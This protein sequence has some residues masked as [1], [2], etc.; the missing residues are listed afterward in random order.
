MD[1][2][3]QI[4]VVDDDAIDRMAIHRSLQRSPLIVAT[5][6][7]ASTGG[8]AMEQLRSRPFHCAFLDYRLPDMDGLALIN[9]IRQ[10]DL[11]TPLIVLTGQGDEET[12]VEL[13][14]AGASDYLVKSRIQPDL[15]A[16]CV[17]SALRVYQAEQAV[18]AAQ[19]E[20]E[21]TNRLLR[22]Q[23]QALEANRR[24]IQRQNLELIRASQLKSDFLATLSH[25]LRTP[26]NAIIGFSQLLMRRRQTEWTDKQREMVGRIHSNGKNLLTLLNEILDFSKLD[27]GRLELNPKP[28]DIAAL[29]EVT[30]AEMRSLAE[31]K[32][33]A[34]TLTLDLTNPT[35]TNDATRLR[36]IVMNLISNAIK[37]TD[38]GSVTVQVTDPGA[39]T[40][41]IAVAD[42]GIGI[43]PE[44]IAA[45]F[46]AFR[47]GDQ[48]QTR[49]HT[50]T[51]L[52]LAIVDSLVVLM[53]G[54]ITVDSKPQQGSTFR[55]QIP[56]HV[57]TAAAVAAN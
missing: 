15:L 28:M 11:A 41:E 54:T 19:A 55:I 38:A 9:L 18:Q 40:I 47:Q 4:L 32:A 27:A 13:M 56:R 17:R 30:V 52:G 31:Q 44:A 6:T 42:T 3:L 10:Q 16:Q 48:T 5:I 43:E 39:D 49:R 34:L 53:G 2:P 20:L 14:K 8:A 29:V 12:A 21:A 46:E 36:Q 57:T 25:E 7:E 35:L 24:H 1:E 26:L 50:G 22:Q 45:I 33:L 51:G 23:N 37:F